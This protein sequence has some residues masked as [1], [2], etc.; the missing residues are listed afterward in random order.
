MAVIPCSSS[1][2]SRVLLAETNHGN[3]QHQHYDMLPRKRHP[4]NSKLGAASPSSKSGT[5]SGAS[6]VGQAG[7]VLVL[8]LLLCPVPYMPCALS[9][10]LPDSIR[11]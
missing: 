6:S 1:S 3:S 7:K 5:G 4:A 10:R 9:L 2:S 8:L 11:A